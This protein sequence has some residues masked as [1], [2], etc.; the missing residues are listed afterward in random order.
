[1]F[2]IKIITT[3]QPDEEEAVGDK[4]N[5]INGELLLRHR[6][7]RHLV[8]DAPGGGEGEADVDDDGGDVKFNGYDGSK[9]VLASC[10]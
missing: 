4:T 1:M 3:N 7:L 2:S 9:A 10:I 5:F 6:V 8:H